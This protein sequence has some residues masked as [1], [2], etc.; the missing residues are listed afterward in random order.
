MI[1]DVDSDYIEAHHVHPESWIPGD[2]KRRCA[3]QLALLVPVD[4]EASP[5]QRARAPVTHFDK[6]EDVFVQSNQVDLAQP[7]PEVPG[8]RL[9]A[10]AAKVLL[11]RSLG[12]GAYN[13][14]VG[15]GHAS[16]SAAS[17]IR[18][19]AWSL[20]SRIGPPTGSRSGSATASPL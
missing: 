5:R 6:Y 17:G 16:S 2:V 13:S 8:E 18:I 14:R 19:S 20:R 15:S 12:S 9:Q 7:A 11:G 1:V 4:G 10:P 3:N